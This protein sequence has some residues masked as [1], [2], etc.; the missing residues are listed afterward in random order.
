MASMYA[1]P[2]SSTQSESI[3]KY[4]STSTHMHS[5]STA[6]STSVWESTASESGTDSQSGSVIQSE[7]TAYSVATSV[8]NSESSQLST[9]ESEDRYLCCVYSNGA[10][11]MFLCTTLR[12]EDSCPELRNWKSDGDFA[13]SNCASQCLR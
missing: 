10:D 8:W 11:D 6:R 2:Q 1:C 7:S 13:V 4:E 12:G 9:S 5:E 3:T